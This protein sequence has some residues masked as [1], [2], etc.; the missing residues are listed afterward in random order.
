MEGAHCEV[1]D[2]GYPG[3]GQVSATALPEA[4]QLPAA[5]A[6]IGVFDSGVGGLSVLRHIRSALPNEHLVY[7]A[8]AGFAPYGDKPDTLVV[9]RSLAIAGYFA[10]IGAKALVVACNTATAAAIDA[11][12]SRYPALVVVGVEPGLKPAAQHSQ[13]GIVGVLATTATLASTR[14]ARLQ[15]QVTSASGVRF[16]LQPCPGLADQIEK[17][18]LRSPATARLL[19]RLL[20]PLLDQGVDTLVLGCTHYPFVQPLIESIIARHRAVTAPP[21]T[22]IDTGAAVARQLQS[23]LCQREQLRQ[24]QAGGSLTALTTG[25]CS[26]LSL[27]IKRLLQVAVEAQQLTAVDGNDPATGSAGSIGQ[28]GLPL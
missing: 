23:L 4:A 25:S 2:R 8:D 6:V 15:A 20:C 16:L 12:R 18:A 11:I 28:T 5:D 19:E 14:F 27:A 1:N 10:G 24:D 17:G 22:L 26:T 13:T 7:L 3:P 9:A 21:V